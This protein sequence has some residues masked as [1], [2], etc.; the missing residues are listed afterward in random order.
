MSILG[1]TNY[2]IRVEVGEGFE[3]KQ[4]VDNYENLRR[5]IATT[6]SLVPHLV[7]IQGL[8][9]KV[10][11]DGEE[12]ILAWFKFEPLMSNSVKLPDHF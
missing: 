5:T 8:D 2:L 7:T 11:K 4:W 9:V 1:S 3:R 10:T 12:T 6:W